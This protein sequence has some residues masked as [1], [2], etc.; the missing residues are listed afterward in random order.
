MEIDADGEDIAICAWRCWTRR[1]DPVPT[2][3]DLIKLQDRR[4]KGTLLGVGNGDPNCQEADNEPKRSLFN[5][6]AQ[7]IV[8]ASKTP[9]EITI[10]AVADG[11]EDNL[12]STILRVKTRQVPA[13][14]VA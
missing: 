11:R 9:G 14:P 13:R 8:Q 3:D 2:A 10:E 6:L 1:A 5:G 4:A 12:P 7:V